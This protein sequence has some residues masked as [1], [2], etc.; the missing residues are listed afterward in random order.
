MYPNFVSDGQGWEYD[1]EYGVEIPIKY[2][3][4]GIDI[5]RHNGLIDWKKSTMTE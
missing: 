5:S 4:H 2:Q 1:K 3:I